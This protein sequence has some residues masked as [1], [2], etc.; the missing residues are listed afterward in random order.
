MAYPDPFEIANDCLAFGVRRASRLVTS[1]YDRYLA[2]AG[3][4][5][6]Q[7]TIL[8]ALRA[9]E[10]VTVSELAGQLQTDRTTLTR[11]LRLLAGRTWVA[12]APGHDR[13]ERRVRLTDSGRLKLEEA[14][15]A[16]QTAQDVLMA[17]LG[18]ARHAR[19]LEDL[20]LLEEAIAL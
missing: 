16:W 14:N 13:R 5:S 3:L 15:D 9:L 6:T 1:H 18:R 10:E 8:N 12:V 2:G 20:S 19:L 11:N 7:F 4:R 17:R